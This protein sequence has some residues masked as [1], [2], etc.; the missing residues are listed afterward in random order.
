[1]PLG[2]FRPC[3]NFGTHVHLGRGFH[4]IRKLLSTPAGKKGPTNLGTEESVGHA[5]YALSIWAPRVRM[6][7]S[8]K[9]DGLTGYV[10][11]LSQ[12]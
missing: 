1:M 10:C 7:F 4:L 12:K 2:I 11:D 6:D 8:V 9:F 3:Q 5:K